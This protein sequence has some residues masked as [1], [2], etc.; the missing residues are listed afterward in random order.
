MQIRLNQS[1]S[2]VMGSNRDFINSPLFKK[3]KIC[4]NTKQIFDNRNFSNKSE[5][6]NCGLSMLFLFDPNSIFLLH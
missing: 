6:P 5:I 1:Q 4:R 3:Q 2:I